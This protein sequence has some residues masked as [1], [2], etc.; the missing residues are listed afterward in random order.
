MRWG[1][2]CARRD[3][4]DGLVRSSRKRSITKERQVKAAE[5]LR[6]EEMATRVRCTVFLNPTYAC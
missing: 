5:K 1:L 2:L 4:A 6:L 3:G